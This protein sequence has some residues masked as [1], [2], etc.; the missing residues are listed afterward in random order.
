MANWSCSS[1]GCNRN[2][3][4]TFSVTPNALVVDVKILPTWYHIP[5]FG[6][7][8]CESSALTKGNRKMKKILFLGCVTQSVCDTVYEQLCWKCIVKR[9]MKRKIEHLRT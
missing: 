6:T 8:N 3:R 2:I 5:S 4:M 7:E 1:R 9:D